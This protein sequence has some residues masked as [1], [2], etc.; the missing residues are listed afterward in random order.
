[1]SQR[2]SDAAAPAQLERVTV[3]NDGEPSTCTV[4]PRN[5]SEEKLVTHWITAE[6]RSFVALDRWQ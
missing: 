1:M 3:T 6:K 5:C 2:M 4:F